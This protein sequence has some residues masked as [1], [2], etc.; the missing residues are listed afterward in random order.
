[1]ILKTIL[2]VENSLVICKLFVLG[3]GIS[4][5]SLVCRDDLF[6]NCSPVSED[7]LENGLNDRD[8]VT[9]PTNMQMIGP[10]APWTT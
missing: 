8:L 6:K 5:N 9:N 2:S 1:M 3:R 10:R 7:F 4:W